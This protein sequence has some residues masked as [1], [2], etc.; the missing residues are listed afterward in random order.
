MCF[1]PGSKLYPNIE[2]FSG[3][4]MR[5]II[6]RGYLTLENYV[7]LNLIM[8]DTYGHEIEH[9]LVDHPAQNPRHKYSH[10]CSWQ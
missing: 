2:I 6:D 8:P 4:I 1:A 3:K 10:L 7:N 5:L 9:G